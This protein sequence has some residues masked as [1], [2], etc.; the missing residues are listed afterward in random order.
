MMRRLQ[1]VSDWMRLPKLRPK[2]NNYAKTMR[3][4]KFI[5]KI[6]HC[7]T[8]YLLI[9]LNCVKLHFKS[10]I[11]LIIRRYVKKHRIF[12]SAGQKGWEKKWIGLIR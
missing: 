5:E 10:N 7:R 11:I 2:M 9:T 1:F 3:F 12:K 6:M 8:F 4:E